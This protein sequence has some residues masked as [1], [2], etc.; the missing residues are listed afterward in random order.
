[1]TTL[2]D[3]AWFI[4]FY[5][6]NIQIYKSSQQNAYLHFTA[7]DTQVLH[8]AAIPYNTLKNQ[9]NA[10]AHRAGD[11]VA[12]WQLIAPDL[13]PRTVANW[14]HE[15]AAWCRSASTA[16]ICSM[17]LY[18]CMY[19]CRCWRSSSQPRLSRMIY[20]SWL[21][22]TFQSSAELSQWQRWIT[23]CQWQWVPYSWARVR[24]A[25]LSIVLSPTVTG[26]EAFLHCWTQT[27]PVSKCCN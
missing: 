4:R 22:K 11:T 9:D 27:A 26:D 20:H 23:N 21:Y 15:S 1:M 19:V 5:G 3:V 8:V 17:L 16:R 7:H 24:E 14:I 18:V 10:T 25:S 12:F 13:P 2:S 6:I